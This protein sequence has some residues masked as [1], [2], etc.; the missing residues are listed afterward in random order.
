MHVDGPLLDINTAPPNLIEQLRAAIDLVRMRHEKLHQSEFG[1]A[2]I[3]LLIAY[4]QPVLLAVEN[5]VA[6][7]NL[8]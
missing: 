7:R 4:R 5:H 8:R 2:N 6:Q 3:Q 1:R